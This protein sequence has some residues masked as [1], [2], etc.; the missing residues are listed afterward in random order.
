MAR[1]WN[2]KALPIV[3]TL[4][5][6]AVAAFFIAHRRTQTPAAETTATEAVSVAQSSESGIPEAAV[7]PKL[8]VRVPM[9]AAERTSSNPSIALPQIAKT[10]SLDILVANVD[11]AADRIT[12]LTHRAHGDVFSLDAENQTNGKPAQSADASIRVPAAAFDAAMQQ[13]ETLGTVRSSSVKAEDL[14]AN[15]TDSS[16]RLRNL[17]RT[18]H[19][20][21]GIMDRSGNVEQIM[22]VENRLSDVREQIETLEADVAS[23]RGRV[24]YATIDIHVQAETQRAPAEPNALT[25]VANAFVGAKHALIDSTVRLASGA[26]W[27]AVVDLPY[28]LAAL[29]TVAWLGLGLRKYAIR[30]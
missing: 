29:L 10:G 12:A 2:R 25:R 14:T 30:R 24:A 27:F 7:A 26:I 23:M 8:A 6:V 4:A 16:A 18:E 21:L 11:T 13:L 9:R 19:D 22:D 5:L 20:I 1:W 17:K 28:V 15:I 3:L